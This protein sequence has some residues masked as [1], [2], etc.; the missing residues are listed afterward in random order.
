MSASV[1]NLARQKFLTEA[2]PVM[3]RA[4]ALSTLGGVTRIGLFVGPFV[5]AGVMQFAGISGAYWV[6]FGGMMAAAALSLTIPDLV[7]PRKRPTAVHHL[8][9]PP[10]GASRFPMPECS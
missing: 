5:G 8:P 7:A 2:V 10:C 1:F 4:R 6:G 9:R 3:F